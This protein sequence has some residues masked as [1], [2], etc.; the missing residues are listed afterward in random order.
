MRLALLYP[1]PKR[2]MHS[3]LRNLTGKT[4]ITAARLSQAR[5]VLAYSRD[6]GNRRPRSIRRKLKCS[7]GKPLARNASS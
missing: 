4:D 7:R 2:G 3:E 1:E 6:G 5:A